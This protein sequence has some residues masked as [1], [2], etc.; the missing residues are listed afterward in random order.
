[1][2][3]P[4]TT[5]AADYLLQTITLSQKGQSSLRNGNR[6]T[7]AGMARKVTLVKLL[8]DGV[9]AYIAFKSVWIPFRTE[10]N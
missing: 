7:N 2:F 10:L 6:Q 3:G 1:M 8:K 9:K 4:D 5:F